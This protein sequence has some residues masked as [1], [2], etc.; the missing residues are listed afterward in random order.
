[1]WVWTGRMDPYSSKT[2]SVGMK[3]LINECK[4]IHRDKYFTMPLLFPGT[5][6]VNARGLLFLAATHV[7]AVAAGFTDE[8]SC[9]GSRAVLSLC[10]EK[11]KK[12]Y[13]LILHVPVQTRLIGLRVNCC[14]AFEYPAG[15]RTWVLCRFKLFCSAGVSEMN[16]NHSNSWSDRT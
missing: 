16:R 4:R 13:K 11:K 9:F 15:H 7:N 2:H 14:T 1:M 10:I 5:S 8:V 12:V 3:H 6:S